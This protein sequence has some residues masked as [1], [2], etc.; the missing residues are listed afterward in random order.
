[1]QPFYNFEKQKLKLK[2]VTCYMK[3]NNSFAFE[4]YFH[5][6]ERG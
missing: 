4:G 3:N 1:M 6:L 2:N 5:A